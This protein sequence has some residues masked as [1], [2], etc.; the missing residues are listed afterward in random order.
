MPGNGKSAKRTTDARSGRPKRVKVMPASGAPPVDALR[1]SSSEHV[2]VVST[3]LAFCGVDVA[4]GARSVG[5]DFCGLL[6]GGGGND[7]DAAAVLRMGEAGKGCCGVGVDADEGHISGVDRAA[8]GGDHVAG[9]VTG[10]VAG[11]GLSVTRASGGDHVVDRHANGIDGDRVA[12]EYYVATGNCVAEGVFAAGGPFV[13]GGDRFAGGDSDASGYCAPGVRNVIDITDRGTQINGGNARY[14]AVSEPRSNYPQHNYTEDGD[15]AVVL[16][17]AE[18][19]GVPEPGSNDSQPVSRGATADRIG[20][21]PSRRTCDDYASWT[22]AQLRKEFSE[23]KLRVPRKFGKLA[24]VEH[25]KRHDTTRRAVQATVDDENLLDPSLRKTKHCCIRLLN[26]LFSDR[27]ATR[28]ASSDDAATRDQI[29]TGEVNQ[30]T[31][32]WKEVAKEFQTNTTDYNGL[33]T[34]NDPR[35]I[36][37]DPSVIVQHDASRL[38][39]MWKKVNTKYIKAFSKFDVSGQNSNDFYEFCDGSL[40]AAYVKVCIKQKPELE[41]YVKGGMHEEDEIDSM[42]LKRSSKGDRSLRKSTKWQDNILTTF[43]RIAEVLIGNQSSTAASTKAVTPNADEEDMLLGRIAK[44]HQV[45]FQVKDSL[46]ASV[47]NGETDVALT[48]SLGLYTK[49][50]QQYESRLAELD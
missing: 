2:G 47:S 13:A 41:S 22:V 49:R 9:T 28:L 37:I 10:H 14:V 1:K 30:N 31:S 46:R 8:G 21:Q 26:V 6:N 11:V 19:R 44:L 18:E 43:D 25:L 27:F 29:D 40:D 50:L 17:N 24:L 45:I 39:D 4:D 42:N 33:F 15:R 12:D 16:S 7:R 23:R 32:F 3:P 20:M 35:Y 36:G 34:F 48:N 38:Y 5:R